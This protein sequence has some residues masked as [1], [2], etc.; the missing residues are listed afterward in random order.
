MMATAQPVEV[1]RGADQASALMHPLRL[2]LLQ[3]LSKP[4]SAT[5]LSRELNI[6]RQKINYHLRELEKA[7]LV[8]LVERRRKGNLMER[9]LRATA[10]SYLISPEVL[11]ALGETPD[12]ARDRFSSAYLVALCAEAIREVGVLRQR[13]AEAGKKLATLSMQT[14]VR[15]ASPADRKAFFEEFAS[16]MA[17]LVTR[18]HDE[19]A[20]DGRIFKLFNISYPKITKP[21]LLHNSDDGEDG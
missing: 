3:R 2:Q 17:E 18:Y 12:Q 20:P 1:I 8:E 9:V 16:F 10:R 14:E 5:G 21:E 6:P 15:F 11:G 7:G 13:S 19:S 4:D